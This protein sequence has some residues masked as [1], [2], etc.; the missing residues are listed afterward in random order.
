MRQRMPAQRDEALAR[1]KQ[2]RR[3]RVLARRRAPWTPLQAHRSPTPSLPLRQS[4]LALLE[5][6]ASQMMPLEDGRRN[7]AEAAVA[8][9]GIGVESNVARLRPRSGRLARRGRRRDAPRAT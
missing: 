4:R 9:R 2:M 6:W 5:T 7:V 3:Q 1:P 8:A